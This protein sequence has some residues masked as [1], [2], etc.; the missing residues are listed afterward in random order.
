MSAI[1]TVTGVYRLDCFGASVVAGYSGR[2][3]D[4]SKRHLFL[5]GLG[6]KIEDLVMVKQVHG[7][8]VLRVDHPASHDP[9]SPA[10]GLITDKK[11]VVLGIRTADCVP[12]F[13]A[14]EKGRALGIAHGGW[15]GIKQGIVP[16]M[17]D[18]F[19]SHYGVLPG[20]LKVAFGPA[21]RA[22]C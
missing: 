11:G 14:D 9:E 6:L 16:N 15:K 3:L 4:N 13:F 21:I 20:D 1:E 22:C 19:Q 2:N 17:I 10:D 12:V 18:F 5:G 7:A 8:V